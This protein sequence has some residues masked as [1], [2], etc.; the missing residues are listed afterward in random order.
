MAI[1][2]RPTRRRRSPFVPRFFWLLLILAALYAAAWFGAV[3]FARSKAGDWL[4]REAEKGRQWACDEP[5]VSGFPF[6][7]RLACANPALS[8]TGDTGTATYAAKTLFAYLDVF[9]PTE[10]TLVFGAP[11]TAKQRNGDTA[12]LNARDVRAVAG[13]ALGGLDTALHSFTLTSAAPDLTF[14]S[15]SGR[16]FTAKATSARFILTPAPG[17]HDLAFDAEGLK[18]PALEQLT[19]N[20]APATLHVA[21]LFE[22]F[23]LPGHGAPAER[24]E[25]WRAAGGVFT[26]AKSTLGNGVTQVEVSGPLALDAEHRPAGKLAVRLVGAGP[27][28]QRFGV[29][30]AVLNPGGLLGALLG[31]NKKPEPEADSDPA[32][33]RLSVT[34]QGGKVLAGPVPLPVELKALY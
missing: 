25:R 16:G 23:D 32:G 2:L 13:L 19:Q 24:L 1:T 8:V 21:G 26:L 30:A 4:A 7:L 20:P 22:K 18:L 5:E 34:L 9:S 10:V 33:L 6:S 28:L 12:L 14:T 11:V 31:K 27:I 3:A 15:V 17:G 29:P